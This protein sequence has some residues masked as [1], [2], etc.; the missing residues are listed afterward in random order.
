MICFVSKKLSFAGFNSDFK[1]A[2]LVRT[3][4][5]Q[6][7]TTNYRGNVYDLKL[8]SSNI[9]SERGTKHTRDCITAALCIL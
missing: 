9:Q 2:I 8:S 4:H 5:R 3:E 7:R 6:I 1:G